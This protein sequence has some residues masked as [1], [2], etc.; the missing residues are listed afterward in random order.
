M[1]NAPDMSAYTFPAIYVKLG[2][3][4]A[5]ATLPARDDE[6]KTYR[7]TVAYDY[8]ERDGSPFAIRAARIV[9]DRYTAE[10]MELWGI[11]PRETV[12]VPGDAGPGKG[13]VILAVPAHIFD[14]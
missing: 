10:M 6:G 7:A 5:R 4:S 11:E 12:M 13:F 3:G 9:W 8:S 14:R 1:S 2:N